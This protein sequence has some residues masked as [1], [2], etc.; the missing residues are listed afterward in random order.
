MLP[1]FE[2]ISALPGVEGIE[3]HAAFIINNPIPARCTKCKRRFEDGPKYKEAIP[4]PTLNNVVCFY[5]GG[6]LIPLDLL[7]YGERLRELP[8]HIK[9]IWREEG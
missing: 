5:C 8:L 7:S 6:R 4:A 9:R 1:G 3:Y 2:D